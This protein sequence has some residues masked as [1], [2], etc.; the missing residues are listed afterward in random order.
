MLLDKFLQDLIISSVLCK[1]KKLYYWLNL[2]YVC[3]SLG[4]KC[5]MGIIYKEECKSVYNLKVQNVI[6]PKVFFFFFFL[7]DRNYT[8]T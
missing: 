4:N 3:N 2:F 8:L 7:Q 6:F 5:K 1:I